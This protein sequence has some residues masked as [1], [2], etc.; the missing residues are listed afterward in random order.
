MTTLHADY[1]EILAIDRSSSSEDIKRAFRRRAK[2]LHPDV[3]ASGGDSVEQMRMLL[4]AY[5]VL[6]NPLR[7]E[8][9]D[10]TLPRRLDKF[11]YREFLKSRR[12]DPESQ[13]RLI[14]FDLLHKHEDDAVA[15]YDFLSTDGFTLEG[16]LNREDFMD[17]AFLLAEEYETRGDYL[18]SFDLFTTLVTYER[19]KPYFRHFFAEIIERLKSLTVT[20]M[21][22]N[23]SDRQ[24]VACLEQL[25]AMNLSRK[26][27]AF[28][29]RK[30]AEYYSRNDDHERAEYYLRRGLELDGSLPGVRKL[31]QRMGLADCQ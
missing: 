26:D 16:K 1:Y 27:S 20:K 4:K 22:G 23:L 12:N 28:F 5:E 31:K 7:R 10:R 6:G 8:E 11:D 30:I 15:L 9:Y 21:R 18:K 24:V 3:S 2:E 29:L 13:S 17:C 14:F 19:E 25:V